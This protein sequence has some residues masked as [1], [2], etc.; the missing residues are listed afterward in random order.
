ME[1]DDY[2][3][4]KFYDYVIDDVEPT[5]AGASSEGDFLAN[6]AAHS[7]LATKPIFH[8]HYFLVHDCMSFTQSK[9]KMQNTS[10]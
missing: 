10:C 6:L 1:V 7:Y 5:G 4:N 9:R 3:H 2:G 8:L